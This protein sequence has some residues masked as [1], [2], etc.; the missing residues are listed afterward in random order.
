MMPYLTLGAMALFAIYHTAVQDRT[1]LR[2]PRPR[3]PAERGPGLFVPQHVITAL[4]C[5]L[6]G[7]AVGVLV[8]LIP[9]MWPPVDAALAVTGLA[10]ALH[11]LRRGR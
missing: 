6:L 7:V 3:R 9:T 1:A 8:W 11:G 2:K 5:L 10:L 4:A